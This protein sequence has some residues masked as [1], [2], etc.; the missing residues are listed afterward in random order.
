V[1]GFV[2]RVDDGP[3]LEPQLVAAAGRD[4]LNAILSKSAATD[5]ELANLMTSAKTE[6]ALKIF[7][8][9]RE[10]TMPEYIND[11]IAFVQ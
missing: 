9:E 10:I 5:V 6:T 11:A 2:G 1:K 8:D 4:A 7:E 3:T